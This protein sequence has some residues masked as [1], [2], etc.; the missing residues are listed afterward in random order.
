MKRA[1]R[2][3]HISAD[4]ERYVWNAGET[5]KSDIYLLNDTQNPVKEF[6]FIA[7]LIDCEG[8]ILAEKS[9]LAETDAN[10]SKKISVIELK[11]PEAMKGKTFFVSAEL[12]DK[13]GKKISDVFYPI[14]VSKTGN[15]EEYNNVFSE[16][17][18]LPK[19]ILKV[20]QVHSELLI[21][22][23]IGNSK[24]RISNTTENLA[25]FTRIRMIEESDSL[26][27]S[28]SDNY[29][30]LLPGETKSITISL[31]NTEP[32]TVPAKVHFEVSSWNSP[33]QTIECKVIGN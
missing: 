32:K 8:K 23:G 17:H 13:S 10:N 12:T 21:K 15:L 14:G 3:I 26:R 28:Y 4:Y 6:T 24:L 29:I 30:S 33:A 7:K 18:Q 22:N 31:E 16:I 19:S 20:E 1:S 9:G 11:I 5:F 27:T 25:F 2:P